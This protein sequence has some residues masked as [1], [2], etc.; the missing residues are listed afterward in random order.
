MRDL[1][2]YIDDGVTFTNL[3][4]CYKELMS[5]LD[6]IGFLKGQ[7]AERKRDVWSSMPGDTIGAK[8]RAASYSVADQ[9]AELERLEMQAQIL[10]IEASFLER[11]LDAAG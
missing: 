8:D 4:I 6:Q 5:V 2:T 7:I 11:L 3:A 10:K 1:L 9:T